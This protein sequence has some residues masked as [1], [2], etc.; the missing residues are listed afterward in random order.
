M[1]ILC[2]DYGDKRIGMAVSDPFGWTAG[3]V[4]TIEHGGSIAKAAELVQDIA[5]EYSVSEI[6]VGMPRNMNGTFG[7]RAQ[8]TE[9]F[10]ESLKTKSDAKIV[11]WDERLT[12]TA[13]KR[14]MHELG[15]KTSKKKNVVDQIAAVHILQGY[16]DNIR[17]RKPD[18][19]NAE[20]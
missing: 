8:I 17:N 15:M 9:M 19:E 11:R 7:P 12:T 2:V 4:K 16:L 3:G 6:V 18:D 5:K 13:A 20:E 14:T 1:R 10:I